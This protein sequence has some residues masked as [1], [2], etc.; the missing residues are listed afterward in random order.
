MLGGLR[1]HPFAGYVVAVVAVVLVL[2]GGA[3]AAGG[4]LITSI[5]QIKPTVRSKLT[6]KTGKTGPVGPAGATG[7]AGG[8]GPAGATGPTGGPGP[9]GAKGT[10]GTPGKSVTVTAI[11]KGKPECADEGGAL[12]KQEG[13][14]SGTEVCNG[15]PWVAGGK[16]PKGKTETGVFADQRPLPDGAEVQLPISFPIPLPASGK[17]Y[18]FNEEQTEHSEFDVIEG[19]ASNCKAGEPKCV[20]SGCTGS[21]E[22][23]TAPEG[24]LCFYTAREI[25]EEA[26]VG[27]VGPGHIVF[28][29]IV[30]EYATS[31]TVLR[32]QN[33]SGFGEISNWQVNGSW[34]VTAN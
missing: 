2:S 12:V 19:S 11:A 27:H 22:A 3:L 28:Q 32:F 23:P 14:A 24:A 13:A 15:S 31:G 29:G 1:R 16:L 34:A 7:P 10:N 17:G 4:Y 25:I 18:F 8:P 6:G 26:G 20:P 9:E 21:V 5:G 30:E 33:E